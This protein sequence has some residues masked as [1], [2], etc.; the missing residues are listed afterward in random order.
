LSC[1][2]SAGFRQSRECLWPEEVE[3]EA[4]AKRMQQPS[5]KGWSSH[6]WKRKEWRRSVMVEVASRG[7]AVVIAKL[8]RH[9]EA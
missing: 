6:D 4:G 9:G 7:M 8:M 3:K 5:R 1:A 2:T